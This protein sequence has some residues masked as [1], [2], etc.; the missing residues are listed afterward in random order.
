MYERVEDRRVFRLS[1]ADDAQASPLCAPAPHAQAVGFMPPAIANLKHSTEATV[2]AASE[3]EH[4][5]S[6]TLRRA[7]LLLF[8]VREY[9]ERVRAGPPLDVRPNAGGIRDG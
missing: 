9:A 2:R 4:V 1:R 8:D 7:P 6:I 5:R 3:R